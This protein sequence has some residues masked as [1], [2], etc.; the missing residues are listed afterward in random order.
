MKVNKAANVNCKQRGC[1]VRIWSIMFT[2]YTTAEEVV[3]YYQ[4]RRRRKEKEEQHVYLSLV[5]FFGGEFKI[6]LHKDSQLKRYFEEVAWLTKDDSADFNDSVAAV[7]RSKVE[8]A[9]MI[10]ETTVPKPRSTGDTLVTQV[11]ILLVAK[12][13][14]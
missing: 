11:N 6:V 14:F 2:T 7:D 9:R 13:I 5:A 10:W 1:G 12:C 4:P 8:K 3:E